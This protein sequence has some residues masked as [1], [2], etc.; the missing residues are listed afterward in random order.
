MKLPSGT[1]TRKN[2]PVFT[3]VLKYFPLALAEISKL[4]K[5]GNDKH[6]PGQPLHWSRDKSTDHGDCLVRHQLDAGTIDPETITADYPE[7]LLHD[8][9]VAWRALAQLEVALE[10]QRLPAPTP[11]PAPAVSDA[12]AKLRAEF[13]ANPPSPSGIGVAWGHTSGIPATETL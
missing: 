4:S 7:G 10:A 5:I 9:H 8:V 3:G 12:Y 11:K 13:A 1:A 6:N 2:L